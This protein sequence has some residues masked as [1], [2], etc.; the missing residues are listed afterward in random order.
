MLINTEDI[1]RAAESF[2]IGGSFVSAAP[3]G[4]GSVH[5]TY[6][7]TTEGG[8]QYVLQKINLRLFPRPEEMM[9][10]VAGI[11]RFLQSE[12]RA[13]GGDPKRETLTLIPTKEGSYV[14]YD[15]RRQ[16][17]RMYL[18]I[19][20]STPCPNPP[21]IFSVT[22][23]GFVYGRFNQ[24]L[25]GYPCKQLKEVIPDYHNTPMHI[26]RL[27]E[28]V[29]NNP[30]KR[31]GRVRYEVDFA[32]VRADEA[33]DL[34]DLRS[35]GILPTRVAHNEA[36][37]TNV[38]L[39][40]KTRDGLCIV[41]LDTVMPGL[42]AYDFGDGVRACANAVAIDETNLSHVHFRLEMLEAFTNGYLDGGGKSL[43]REEYEAL[44]YGVKLMTYELAV[45][46]LTDY[47]NGDQVFRVKHPEQNIDRARN[48][49]RLV[50]DI[51]RKWGMVCS[52]VEKKKQEI[53]RANGRY[54]PY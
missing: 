18:Y 7:I 4:A 47:I 50:Q 52:V 17:W 30:F 45:R 29:K 24:L 16:C 1:A 19:A 5:E 40:K 15:Q 41:N 9:E 23:A 31:A 14:H 34:V 38:L 25:F 51:E 12:L 35:R 36:K 53:F 27:K 46:Y 6:L 21:T 48:Q 11:S 44:P 20:G 22:A 43:S 42:S 39:D 33:G 32:L 37:T 49:F 54:R 26:K 28:A 2:N 13:R 3:Y 8:Q 10:N